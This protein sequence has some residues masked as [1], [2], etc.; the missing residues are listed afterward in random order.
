[1]WCEINQEC[2]DIYKRKVDEAANPT[3][4]SKNTFSEDTTY[5]A[6]SKQLEK[7]WFD[8]QDNVDEDN[9][10]ATLDLI[11]RECLEVYKRKA[12]E[13]EKLCAN[14]QHELVVAK[15][16]LLMLASALGVKIPHDSTGK[17]K[18]QLADIYLKQEHLSWLKDKRKVV[19]ADVQSQIQKLREEF[20]GNSELTEEPEALIVSDDD[21]SLS[22]LGLL[23]SE[24]QSL[25][26]RAAEVSDDEL[27]QLLAAKE[28]RAETTCADLLKQLHQIWDEVGESRGKRDEVLRQINQEYLGIYKRNLVQDA[29]SGA[30]LSQVCE[31]TAGADYE[32]NKREI[33]RDCLNV[34]MKKVAKAAKSRKLLRQELVHAKTEL[35]RLASAL[36]M[37]TIDYKST[38]TISKQLAAIRLKLKNLAV[39]K[40]KRKVLFADVQLQIQEIL[41]ETGEQT[42]APTVNEDDLSLMKLDKLRSELQEFQLKSD[43]F[44][45]YKVFT[46]V[47]TMYGLCSVLEINFINF[48]NGILPIDSRGKQSNNGDVS[49]LAKTEKYLKKEELERTLSKLTMIV[50]DL[51]K[52]KMERHAMVAFVLF[53]LLIFR[54]FLHNIQ[55]LT[56]QLLIIYD[57]WTI[58]D[59]PLEEQAP[60]SRVIRNISAEV[61]D[62]IHPGDL[63]VCLIKHVSEFR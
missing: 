25:H 11:D 15:G 43:D 26:E 4:V 58:M 10:K 63:G 6:L 17:V 30:H 38:G 46:C 27:T 14:L 57:L 55:H 19:F 47:T 3:Q 54:Y 29:R 56:L 20:A 36:G 53:H 51:K 52:E 8:L 48:I 28:F 21:L 9:R 45:A 35:S 13:A 33:E 59:T 50:E 1:M 23:R 24:L 18:K 37:K 49:E 41:K 2:L 42:E 39:L 5:E 16:E 32:T 44:K 31:N 62:V 34:Y 61:D 7:S 40:D 12:A 60:F 22:T